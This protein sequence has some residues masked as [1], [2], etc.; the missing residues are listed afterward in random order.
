MEF[1]GC[2]SAM[3][4]GVALDH[5]SLNLKLKGLSQDGAGVYTKKN[6]YVLVAF[7]QG[8][9]KMASLVGV[10]V[11]LWLIDGCKCHADLIRRSLG[12]GGSFGGLDTLIGLAH[13][14]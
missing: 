8:D 14:A 1:A 4:F 5:F 13:V 3:E 2:Q 7:A 6:H 11:A 12:L 9:G 10:D